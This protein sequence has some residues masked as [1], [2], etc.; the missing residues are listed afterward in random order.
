MTHLPGGA[1]GWSA[2]SPTVPRQRRV[3]ERAPL[4][5]EVFLETDTQFF[6]G[7]SAN[8]SEGGIFV[9]TYRKC[10]VGARVLMVF[11]LSGEPI[12]ARGTVRWARAARDG[13]LGGLGIAFEG[14]PDEHRE[15]I[16]RFSGGSRAT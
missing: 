10:D 4:V 5:V 7:L 8:V 14:L 6:A 16:R 15:R 11:Y 2:E 13:Q 3:W 9:Q 1:P 12:A